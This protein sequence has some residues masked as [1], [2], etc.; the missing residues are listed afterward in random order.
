MRYLK[1]FKKSWISEP[2]S[3]SEYLE[4]LLWI[5]EFAGEEDQT[6]LCM[7]YLDIID[8]LGVNNARNIAI[9]LGKEGLKIALKNN[10]LD[11]ANS[12]YS[13]LGVIEF[14]DE[15][16]EKA[17]AYFQKVLQNKQ[18]S[19]QFLL[20]LTYNNIGQYYQDVKKD[21]QKAESYFLKTLKIVNHSPDHK[22][23]KYHTKGLLGTCY[24]FQKKNEKA[25]RL[26]EE[27]VRFFTEL[28]SEPE[29]YGIE[30]PLI[31]LVRLYEKSGDQ[32]NYTKT[33]SRLK[34]LETGVK[35]TTFS[36]SFTEVLL[37]Y[38]TQKQQKQEMLYYSKRYIERFQ[39]VS[40]QD[41]VINERLNAMIYQAQIKSSRRKFVL[42]KRILQDSI[43]AK[44]NTTWWIIIV[45]TLVTSLLI[46]VYFNRLRQGKKNE[47]IAAQQVQ[48]EENKRRL[49]ENEVKLKQEKISKMS[50]SLSLKRETEEAFLKKLKEIKRKKNPDIEATIIDLQLSIS[51]LLQIDQKT[52]F[53]NDESDLEFKFCRQKLKEK[54]PELTEQEINLCS[55][56]R[57]NLSSK[58]ISQ[59]TNM[60]SGTIRVY[61][62]KIKA[63]IGLDADSNLNDYLNQIQ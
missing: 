41:R 31:Q 8:F 53:Q 40:N 4:D 42:E 34:Q 23:L 62:T 14:E 63:K 9:P 55:Y 32:T 49:L 16:N 7:T 59:I 45:F 50:I 58:E 30:M 19:D 6:I 21:Y 28:K 38:Y 25:I 44:R 27:E 29:L 2:G 5:I 1:A 39:F 57:L 52:T 61:K 60:T 35:D 11:L 13:M 10:R 47:L 17:M 3:E 48:L 46:L 37:E 43:D 24:Y 15:H 56:F 22:N 12:F 51:N 36:I 18:N 33:L 26:L 54:H 20:A